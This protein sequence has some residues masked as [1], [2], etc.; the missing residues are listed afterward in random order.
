MKARWQRVVRA[1]SEPSGVSRRSRALRVA[2][3][4]LLALCALAALWLGLECASLQVRGHNERLWRDGRLGRDDRVSTGQRPPGLLL[5]AAHAGRIGY[6][7]QD[8]AFQIANVSAVPLVLT[9][10]VRVGEDSGRVVSFPASGITVEAGAHI[11]CARNALTFAA[12]FGFT[13]ALE[14]G[15]DSTPDVPNLSLDSDFRLPDAGGSLYLW[16]ATDPDACNGDGGPWPA[17]ENEMRG[18]MERRDPTLPGNDGNWATSVSTTVG[19]DARGN[20]ILGTP[21]HTNSARPLSAQPASEDASSHSTDLSPIVVATG[22]VINEV[23]WAGTPASH[24]DEWIELY[25][26]TDREVDLRGWLLTAADGIPAVQLTGVIP[27]HGFYLL[28]RTDDSTVANIPADQIYTGALENTGETLYLYGAGIIDALAYGSTSDLPP[29]WEGPPLQFYGDGRFAGSGQILFRKHDELTGLPVPDTDAAADWANSSARGDLVYGPVAEGDLYGKRVMYPGW[30]WGPVLGQ[31]LYTGTLQV[32]ATARVTVVVAPD[33]AYQA[34][35]DLLRSARREILIGGYTFESVWLTG[36]LT[37]RLAAGVSVTL[38]LEGGPAGGLPEAELWGCEQIVDAGGQALFMH[39]DDAERIFGRYRYYHAKYV[40]VDGRWAAIGS[41][42][43]GNHAM[44][45]DDKADGTAGDRGILLIVDQPQVVDSVRD[46]FWRD[47]DPD[48]HRDVMAYGH[49]PRYVV[50]PSYTPV[51]STG[52]GGYAYMAPY[53]ATVPAFEADHWEIVH[54]P[55]TALRLSDGLIGLILKAGAGDEVLVEQMSEP[56][57]WGGGSS[58]VPS[59]PNPRLEAYI[60]AA[61]Q[62][63]QVR[64]LLDKGMDDQRL[65]Y[66]T[67]FYLYDVALREGLDLEVRLG[68]PTRRGIHN[69][70]ALVRR[71]EDSYVHVGSVNGSE[72]SSKANRELALQVRSAGAYEFLKGVFEYDWTHSGGPFEVRLPLVC[73]EYVPEADH[74]VISEVVFKLSGAD[75]AGEWV[76]LYNPTS[77]AVDLGG[78]RVGDAVRYEDYER[79]YAFPAGTVLLPGETLVVTRRAKFYQGIGYVGRPVPDYEWRDSNKV[80]DLIRTAWGEGEF[81][82]GNDGDE[83]LLLDASNQVVDALVYGTGVLPGTASFG[84]VSQVYNGSSLERWPA[85]RD[86]DDC[87]RNFRV[88]YAPDPGNAKSW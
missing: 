28:E 68:D 77:R 6:S 9:D 43:F 4:T 8:E 46:L 18:S 52:G 2:K 38:F 61:R 75:E 16:R 69:K 65:N 19:V 39:D 11:W 62:G 79:R 21:G 60:Q 87:R 84:D 41:E 27:A 20:A 22:V 66:A 53:S 72:I 48:R 30:E 3:M 23:A 44:P 51:Y 45:V 33:N 70:M 7:G 49:A 71:G 56:V 47:S 35:A 81:I 1:M 24:Y 58:D 10:E 34:L 55:E 86:S 40:V 83:V 85:N 31:R 37:E 73:N 74:V 17:G 80:P 88:R 50:P 36:V 76:E 29:G 14:Y 5:S 25:N 78:W 67:A 42:N 13:P 12:A 54:A 26:N 57:H 15:V 59:D 63:A 82:L 64:I 32:T